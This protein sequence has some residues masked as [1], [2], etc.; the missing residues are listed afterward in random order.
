MKTYTIDEESVQQEA[1]NQLQRHLTKKELAYFFDGLF[2]EFALDAIYTTLDY[3]S[4]LSKLEKEWR[5]TKTKYPHYK[6]LSKNE[7]AFQHTFSTVGTFSRRESA[8]RYASLRL[9]SPSEEWRIYLV[10]A[11]GVEEEVAHGANKP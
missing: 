3:L 7:N 4:E 9:N 1:E 8:E 10:T 11:H 2:A 6:L 5:R